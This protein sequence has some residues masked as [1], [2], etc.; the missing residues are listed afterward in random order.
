ME[1]INLPFRKLE[2]TVL[3]KLNN[4]ESYGMKLLNTLKYPSSLDDAPKHYGSVC[5]V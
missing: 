2:I 1:I 5:W 4:E 3:K